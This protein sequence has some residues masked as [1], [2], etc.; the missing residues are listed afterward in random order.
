MSN[1][2]VEL[3]ATVIS[4][5]KE[6]LESLASASGLTVGEV[7]DRMLLA[8]S[9]TDVNDAFL[10]I[11]DQVLISTRQLEPEQFNEVI[12]KLLQSIENAFAKD[13]PEEIVKTLK[14]IVNKLSAQKFIK[15][16]PSAIED[17]KNFIHHKIKEITPLDDYILEIKFIEG[18]TKRY[19]VK[20]LFGELPHF[21]DLKENDLF[22]KVYVS[23]GGYGAIWNDVLDL[24]CNELWYNGTIC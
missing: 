1:K 3:K 2:L 20:P 16:N 7:I 13:E 11:L 4:Q 17:V 6:I 22:S 24:D 18:C 14:S 21:T 15:N 5:S 19:D 23:S 8:V 9:P 10:L 12:L